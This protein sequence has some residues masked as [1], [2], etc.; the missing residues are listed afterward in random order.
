[1]DVYSTIKTMTTSKRQ[2]DII[3]LVGLVVCGAGCGIELAYRASVALILITVG[4]IAF[5]IGTK[6]KSR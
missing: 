6:I 4:S 3:Q 1:M 5:A 2:G